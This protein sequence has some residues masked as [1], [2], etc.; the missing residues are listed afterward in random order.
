[1]LT[2][3]INPKIFEIGQKPLTQRLKHL[4]IDTLYEYVNVHKTQRTSDTRHMSARGKI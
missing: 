1:M 2:N 3:V 4:L